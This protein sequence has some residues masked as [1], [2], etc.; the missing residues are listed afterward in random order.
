[1]VELNLLHTRIER[2]HYEN[3]ILRRYMLA[4]LGTAMLMLVCS[5]GWLLI[6][7][8]HEQEA[9]NHLRETIPVPVNTVDVSVSDNNEF[10]AADILKVLSKSADSTI[11]GVCYTQITR[12]SSQVNLQGNAWTLAGISSLINQISAVGLFAEL[13]LLSIKHLSQN[14]LFQFNIAAREA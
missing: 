11:N 8:Q 9:L 14:G 1:M 2:T 12:D 4:A 7:N 6:M 5:H 3:K 10:S 13:H